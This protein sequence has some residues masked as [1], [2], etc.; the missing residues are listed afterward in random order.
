M[1]SCS[2]FGC[3]YH[4]R[5]EGC[6]IFFKMLENGC[7]MLKG[8]VDCYLKKVLMYVLKSSPFDACNRMHTCKD[9][10]HLFDEC[11]K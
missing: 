4:E 2:A 8:K 1:P 5:K 9:T 7:I 11:R 10:R 6:I 3:T